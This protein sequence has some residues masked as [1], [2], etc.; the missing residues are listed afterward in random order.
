MDDARHKLMDPK[1]QVALA[2]QGRDPR[3]IMDAMAKDKDGWAWWNNALAAGHAGVA[4]I[5]GAAIPIWAMQGNM[6]GISASVG[7]IGA[8]GGR[9]MALYEQAQQMQAEADRMRAGYGRSPIGANNMSMDLLD[10]ASQYHSDGPLA[11]EPAISRMLRQRK[12]V[13][14]GEQ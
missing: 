6:P 8:N 2:L 9:A 7:M 1:E 14:D 4:G 11:G 3:T 13:T 5:A 10:Y 12:R